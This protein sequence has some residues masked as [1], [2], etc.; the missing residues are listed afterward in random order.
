MQRGKMN[1]PAL[2][3]AG[4][5]LVDG[6]MKAEDLDACRPGSGHADVAWGMREAM[7]RILYTVVHSNAMNG[8][9][10]RTKIVAVTP[11]WQTAITAAQICTGV[12][13]L[14]A[15]VFLV[16]KSRKNVQKA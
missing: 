15:I 4:G 3:V 8:V 9:S 7:H 13:T 1:L 14:A 10:A 5:N 11:W 6:M 2:L 12:L 16:I